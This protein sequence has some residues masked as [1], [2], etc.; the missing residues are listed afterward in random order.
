VTKN[1]GGPDRS[2]QGEIEPE[3]K[4]HKPCPTALFVPYKKDDKVGRGPPTKENVKDIPDEELLRYY[5]NMCYEAHRNASYGLPMVPTKENYDL[6]RD[7]II[8]RMGASMSFGDAKEM[9]EQVQ[10]CES[11]REYGEAACY[12]CAIGDARKCPKGQEVL[13]KREKELRGE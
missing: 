6:I 11:Y 2:G 4:G 5:G 10:S 7:E 3:W 8:R 1:K 12:K 13:K 9:V